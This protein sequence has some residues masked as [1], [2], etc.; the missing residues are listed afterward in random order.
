MEHK[1][2]Q[3]WKG[4]LMAAMD[5]EVGMVVQ[6]IQGLKGSKGKMVQRQVMS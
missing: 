3:G 5:I 6:V 2:S 1:V 4:K